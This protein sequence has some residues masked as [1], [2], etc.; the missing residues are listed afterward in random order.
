ML[1]QSHIAPNFANAAPATSPL[2]M[3]NIEIVMGKLQG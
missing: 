1:Q 3:F 2:A